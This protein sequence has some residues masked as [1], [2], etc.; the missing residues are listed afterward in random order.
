M[1]VNGSARRAVTLAIAYLAIRVIHF[2][3]RNFSARGF[4]VAR[5]YVRVCV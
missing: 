4:N 5:V 3:S 1:F 2:S